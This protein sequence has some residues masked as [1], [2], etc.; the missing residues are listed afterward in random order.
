MEQLNRGKTA[1]LL[2]PE[3]ALTPQMIQTFSSHFGDDVAVL[4]SSLSVGERYDE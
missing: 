3:I 2:V 1:I 4:H